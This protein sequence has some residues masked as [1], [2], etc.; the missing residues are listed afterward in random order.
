MVNKKYIYDVS[1]YGIEL[2][3]FNDTFGLLPKT[4]YQYQITPYNVNNIPSLD[5]SNIQ[6]INNVYTE[7]VITYCNLFL[8]NNSIILTI[9]GVYDQIQIA[10]FSNDFYNANNTSV[11]EDFISYGFGQNSL[12][13]TNSASYDVSFINHIKIADISINT[14]INNSSVVNDFYKDFNLI[15]DPIL[16]ISY[17]DITYNSSFTPPSFHNWFY[18]DES[19]TLNYIDLSI[20]FDNARV[21][22]TIIPFSFDYMN[23]AP[24]IGPQYST[25]TVTFSR[26]T[27]I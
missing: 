11:V 25:I 19:N 26:N 9:S 4:Y 27:S 14:I 22:Y 15:Y 20:P 17:Y 6:I 13:G 5:V 18:Y 3:T 10:R 21:T 2:G 23:N 16:N 8:Q 24:I 12:T 7:P 1:Y